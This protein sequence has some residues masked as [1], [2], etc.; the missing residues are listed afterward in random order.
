MNESDNCPEC[1]NRHIELDRLQAEYICKKCGLVIEEGKLDNGYVSQAIQKRAINPYL[2]NSG[3]K[4]T[5]G[6]IVKHSWLLS[7]REKNLKKGYDLIELIAGRLHLQEKVKREAQYIYKRALFEGLAVGR[8][9]EALLHA[10]IYIACLIHEVPKTGMEI[11]IRSETT[12]KQLYKA[13]KLIT[14]KLSIAVPKLDPIDLVPRY[15]SSLKLSPKT[16]TRTNEILEKI[17]TSNIKNGKKAETLVAGALY[18]ATQQ[19]GEKRSQREIANTVGVIEVTI[20][21]IKKE[22]LKSV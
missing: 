10:S 12:K 18:L 21:K 3:T 8:N 17:Q 11:T 6:R 16:I 22:F 14:R 19:T 4:E 5:H 20:R 1:G 9:K 15:A 7:T 13:V 2:L